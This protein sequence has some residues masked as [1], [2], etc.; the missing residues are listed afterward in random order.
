MLVGN[1]IGFGT[2]TQFT[3]QLLCAPSSQSLSLAT[4]FRDS[5]FTAERPPCSGCSRLL[6]NFF[7]NM[8]WL[9]VVE[10]H[11]I[12]ESQLKSQFLPDSIS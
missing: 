6:V 4:A 2:S 8:L 12:I 10:H 9:F 1:G 7:M 5:S 3:L 11:K